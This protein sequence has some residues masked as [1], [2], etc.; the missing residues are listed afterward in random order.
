M[1]ARALTQTGQ[2]R[3][4][5]GAVR[6]SVTDERLRLALAATLLL[7]AGVH[8][9]VGIQ[10][11][12]SNFAA[13]AVLSAFSQ[14]GLAIGV[15]VRPSTIV[16]GTAVVVSLVLIQVYLVNVT[17][18]L[19]PV[20]AHSHSPG[21]HQIFGVA[22]AWPAPIDGEGVVAK[23]AELGTVVLGGLLSRPRR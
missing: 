1:S 6:R 8:A 3:L 15:I 2:L 19:P 20:I 16:Y 21:T 18:G 10:H 23:I 13:L 5:L 17:I 11:S 14:L 7:G 22:L 4:P 12:P 9:A